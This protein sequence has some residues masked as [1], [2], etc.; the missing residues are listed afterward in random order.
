MV[1]DYIKNIEIQ[2]IDYSKKVDN[3]HQVVEQNGTGMPAYIFIDG[4]AIEV[5]DYEY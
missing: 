1:K 3:M 4:K 5:D 2:I